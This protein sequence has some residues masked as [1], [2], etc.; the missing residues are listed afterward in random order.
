MTKKETT[1]VALKCFAVYILSQV[2][3]SLPSLATLGTRLKYMGDGKPSNI[4]IISISGLS[5]LVGLLAAFLIWKFTNSLLNKETT[6]DESSD[7]GVSGVM[8][9]ILACMGV[10]FI[11][12]AA[13]VFP[14]A[15]S[16]YR[17]S[18]EVPNSNPNAFM[19]LVTQVIE[20]SFGCLLIAK[21]G[22]WVKAIRSIGEI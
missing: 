11:I 22:R 16:S 2:I 19:F 18:V 17:F 14:M 6:P 13:M 1:A 9:I 20:F 15:L 21:P 12:D 10:Y 8:K 4:W 5:V 7:I 3:I